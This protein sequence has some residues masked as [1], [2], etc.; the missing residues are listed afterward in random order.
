MGTNFYR[1]RPAR[2]LAYHHLGKRSAAGRFCWDCNLTLHRGGPSQIHYSSEWHERCPGCGA[3]PQPVSLSSGAAAVELGFAPAAMVRPTGVGTCASFT[4]AAP[5]DEV[6]AWC[7]RHPRAK[8]IEDEYGQMLSGTEFLTMLESC[9]PIEF[10]HA[11][12]ERFS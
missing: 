7:R 4:W 12:G 8:I 6:V 9:C 11:V 3:L 1:D 10:H 5:K 2:G